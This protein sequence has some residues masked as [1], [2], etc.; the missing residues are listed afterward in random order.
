MIFTDWEFS[1]KRL[2]F[3]GEYHPYRIWNDEGER[4]V[5]P[6]FDNHCRKILDLKERKLSAVNYFV[7]QIDSHIS[8]GVAIAYVPSHDSEKTQSGVRDVAI[9]IAANGR[10]D[11]T[12]CLVRHKTVDKLA[13]GG[14]RD[15][16]V[17]L[18][19]IRVQNK[20]LIRGKEVLLLDDVTTSG[21]SLT[22]CRKI[23]LDAGA[24][25][26]QMLAFAR[27]VH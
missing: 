1:D 4:V 15:S 5:N 12:G 11:A 24:T 17:H 13:T 23:L 25:T 20:I 21:N 6:K 10:I 22:A 3:L 16:Q 27:T 14:A 18:D 7:K 9:A 2:V 8:A 19:S 26:V